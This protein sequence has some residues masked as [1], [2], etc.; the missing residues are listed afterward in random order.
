VITSALQ[1]IAHGG[2]DCVPLLV[3]TGQNTTE[4][5][6]NPNILNFHFPAKKDLQKHKLLL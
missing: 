4:V 6:K 5:S 1:S 2:Q 3:I